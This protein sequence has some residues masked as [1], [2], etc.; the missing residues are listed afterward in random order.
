MNPLERFS[1]RA[2]VYARCR[3]TYP[4]QALDAA[5]AGAPPGVAADVGA[6]TGISA[7]LLARRGRQVIAIEPNLAM[8]EEGM[9]V[10]DPMIRWLDGTGERTGLDSASVALVLCAQ[11]FH[12]L[13]ADEAL[14]E[15]RRILIPGGRAAIAWNIHD[16]KDAAT[17]A[18]RA[19]ILRHCT[20]PPTSPWFTQTRC[21]LVGA[22]GWST[23]RE[24]RFGH[25]QLLDRDGL[26]GRA[27]SASYMPTTGP[28]GDAARR[29]IEAVFDAHQQGGIFAFRL[30]C[31][32]YVAE[33]LSD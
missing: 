1:D 15:F 3:P 12:W 27:M 2:Q 17:S 26:V 8:R 6:G 5:L 16:L 28:R 14:A 25:E 10:P 13:R 31:E 22:P 7:R 29:G 24:F 30:V 9:R 4:E 20:D 19:A 23:C 21:A 32:V 11:A 18:F 33:R